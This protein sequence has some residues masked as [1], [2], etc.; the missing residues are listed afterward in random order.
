MHSLI[1]FAGGFIGSL[2]FGMTL[3]L[4]GPWSEIAAWGVAFAVAGLVT[5]IGPLMLWIFVRPE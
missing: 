2:V 5:V 4:I 3:D 1:G